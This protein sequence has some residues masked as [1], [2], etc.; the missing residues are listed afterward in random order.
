[1]RLL[2][3]RGRFHSIPWRCASERPHASTCLKYSPAI[4]AVA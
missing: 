3:V 1:M 4:L 2:F